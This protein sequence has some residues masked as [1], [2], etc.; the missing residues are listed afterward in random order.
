MSDIVSIFSVRWADDCIPPDVAGNASDAT[1]VSV[2]PWLLKNYLHSAKFDSLASGENLAGPGVSWAFLF[3]STSIF[4]EGDCT[5]SVHFARAISAIN[6]A[7]REHVP[8]CDLSTFT[9]V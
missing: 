9:S 4:R 2:A 6:P 3:L 7:R 1:V 5:R 8:M